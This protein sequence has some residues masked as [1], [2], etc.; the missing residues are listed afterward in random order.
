MSKI[1]FRFVSEERLNKM[2]EG[3]ADP[4]ELL[5]TV[6]SFFAFVIS[7]HISIYFLLAQSSDSYPKIVSSF[8]KTIFWP[9]N[10]QSSTLSTFSTVINFFTGL[11]FNSTVFGIIIF[12]VQSIK[13]VTNFEVSSTIKL[14]SMITKE[15]MRVSNLFKFRT[16]SWIY[17]VA[18]LIFGLVG[19]NE[20]VNENIVYKWGGP[21]TLELLPI[22]A[23]EK[24]F[25]SDEGLNTERN[26]IQPWTH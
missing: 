3:L 25:F 20:A 17:L 14:Y 19:C 24:G 16:I 2:K 9:G 11:A 4:L 10:D 18:I 22:L 21:K 12:I 1:D 6:L 7:I 5:G 8:F 26:D 13:D 15:S 23:Q